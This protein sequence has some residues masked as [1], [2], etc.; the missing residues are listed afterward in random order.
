M[1]GYGKRFR[2]AGYDLPKYAIE[3]NGRTL[4]E[5][6]ML[7]LSNIA[8]LDEYIFVV[9]IDD[10]AYDFIHEKCRGLN[11]S[12]FRVLELN[13]PTN[14]QAT[15][16]LMAV[17]GCRDDESILIYNIDTFVE[18]NCLALRESELDGY[19]VCFKAPGSHWSFVGLDAFGRVVEVREKERISDYATVGLYWFKNKFIYIQAYNAM[20][21]NNQNLV[22]GEAYVAPL[23]N[24]LIANGLKVEMYEVPF[25]CVHSLGTPEELEAF[26][27]H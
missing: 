24:N 18:P 20:Y 26:K 3:V 9:R 14:G 1:A 21:S 17:A 22:S 10:L 6:A 23:Y 27:S 2:V 11:I 16:A 12:N 15:T 13:S 25:E 19:I 4:F 8:S 5:W 7:S